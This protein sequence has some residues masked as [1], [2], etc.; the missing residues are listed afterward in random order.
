[1]PVIRVVFHHQQFLVEVG[2]PGVVFR[3]GGKVRCTDNIRLVYR[4]SGLARFDSLA[5]PR[6]RVGILVLLRH[7]IGNQEFDVIRAVA[8]IIGINHVLFCI[9]ELFAIIGNC[10]FAEGIF[11]FQFRRRRRRREKQVDAL[12]LKREVLQG[13]ADVD[14][15][16]A[17]FITVVIIANRGNNL[18]KLNLSCGC[19]L[20]FVQ[21]VGHWHICCNEWLGVI[22]LW[23][24]SSRFLTLFLLLGLFIGLRKCCR[25][26]GYRY[27]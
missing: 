9:G 18:R 8:Q 3:F 27:Q 24:S 21:H 15:Q 12:L 22:L 16:N 5:D 14:S 2:S 26:S 13:R 1:M 23:R 11:L 25:C 10:A 7:G 4:P 6:N 20:G 19:V 17:C